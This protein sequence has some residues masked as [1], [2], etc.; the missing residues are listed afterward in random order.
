[1]PQL[2]SYELKVMIFPLFNCKNNL[3]FLSKQF[4]FKKSLCFF[5]ISGHLGW[6]SVKASEKDIF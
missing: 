2:S 4:A 5:C 6:P 1:V 3:E